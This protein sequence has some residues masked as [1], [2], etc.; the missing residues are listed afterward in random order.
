M[1]TY[2]YIRTS[3]VVSSIVPGLVYP[4]YSK[5]SIKHIP[6]IKLIEKI[7]NNKK[8]RSYCEKR[9]TFVAQV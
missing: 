9:N 2:T 8:N 1:Q 3:Y 4:V 5:I 7:E 6:N